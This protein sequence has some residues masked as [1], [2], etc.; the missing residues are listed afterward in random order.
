[1]MIK[2]SNQNTKTKNLR[3]IES[4][5]TTYLGGKKK[6]YSFDLSSGFSCPGAKDC[7]SFAVVGEDG[8]ATIK[9]GPFT[10]FRCFSASQEVLFPA[11]RKMRTDN[12]NALKDCRTISEMVD[13]LTAALP[14][15]AGIVRLHV[16][17]DMFSLAYM[18]AWMI[19]AQNHPEVLFYFYTKSLH[20]LKEVS[21][22][23][24]DLANGVIYPNLLVTASFGGRHDH[25]IG[26]LNV[27]ATVVVYSENEAI[28][29]N[30]VI[31]HDDSHAA[32][33]GGSFALLIH[34]VQPKGS[35]A[36]VALSTIKKGLKN[37][38]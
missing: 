7:Q 31:D 9:D 14:S 34:G 15:N 36:S 22:E 10:L 25:L 21:A 13:I 6:I 35:A 3:K 26:E 1:M 23:C 16:A 5:A 19:V 12:F 17:G 18:R 2:F 8:R 33:I 20:H 30:L 38:E 37:A 28:E 32:T 27:R 11:V 4:L 29:K 24:V